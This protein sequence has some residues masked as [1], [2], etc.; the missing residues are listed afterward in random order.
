MPTF[1]DFGTRN[2]GFLLILHFGCP[3]IPDKIA[4]FAADSL[5]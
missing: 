5:L 2:I 1:D 4:T 3:V